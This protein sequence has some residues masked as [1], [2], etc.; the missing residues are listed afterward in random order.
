MQRRIINFM[1]IK[2]MFIFPA[3]STFLLFIALI[4]GCLACSQQEIYIGVTDVA[5]CVSCLIPVCLNVIAIV[6]SLKN[7][8]SMVLI[9]TSIVLLV[10]FIGNTVMA[11]TGTIALTSADNYPTIINTLTWTFFSMIWFTSILLMV[12]GFISNARRG[13]SAFMIAC[14]ILAIFFYVGFFIFV[15]IDYM[16]GKVQTPY[17]IPYSIFYGVSVLTIVGTSLAIAIIGIKKPE[18][19]PEEQPGLT[20][21]PKSLRLSKEDPIEEIKK[22][23]ELLDSGALTQEEFDAKKE[24]ILNR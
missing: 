13:G 10:S 17:F 4:F 22:W 15:V 23:K 12:S 20:H 18:Q 8:K 1:N 21:T 2:K 16:V 14:A 11:A 19:E 9:G 5:V 7:S 3:I 6:G 24:E